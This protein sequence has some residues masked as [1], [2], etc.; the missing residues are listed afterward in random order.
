MNPAKSKYS[1]GPA[2]KDVTVRVDCDE[3]GIELD[4]DGTN[5]D[6]TPTHVKCSAKFDG[7]D[8][9]IIGTY[10][11][12]VPVKRIDANT[13]QAILKKNDGLLMLT[14]IT[15]VSADG[16]TRTSTF[17]GKDGEDREVNNVVLYNK[18]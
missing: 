2:P 3:N 15:T 5:A 6:R 14:V 12:T 16:K 8:Y 1:P 10:A 9:P 11:D 7:K 18:Q 4:A 17:K 13:M